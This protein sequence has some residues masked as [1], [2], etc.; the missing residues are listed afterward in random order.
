M[1]KIFLSLMFILIVVV[2][3]VVI[4]APVNINQATAKELAENLQGVGI[5]K[6]QAIVQYREKIGG[7]KSP[8][9]LLNVK[10]IGASTLEKNQKNILL[11]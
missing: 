4:A 10:G 5:K 9:Q 8:E 11:E 6:A 2:N 3:S 1:K 7:F